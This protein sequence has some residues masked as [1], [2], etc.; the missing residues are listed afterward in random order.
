MN[1]ARSTKTRNTGGTVVQGDI[2][3]EVRE[4]KKEN[5]DFPQG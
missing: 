1:D 5:S 3:K 2:K 4:G